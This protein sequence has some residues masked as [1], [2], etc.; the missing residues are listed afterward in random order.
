M[1]LATCQRSVS[2]TAELLFPSHPLLQ[3]TFWKEVTMLS[4][5]SWELYFSF[6]NSLLRLPTVRIHSFKIHSFVLGWPKFA[7]VFLYKLFCMTLQKNPGKILGQPNTIQW[8]QKNRVAKPSSL[9][10]SRTFHH[11]KRHYISAGITYF[12][13][14]TVPVNHESIFRLYRFALLEATLP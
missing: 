9:S 4:S 3:G 6:L 7:W 10:K 12:P 5:K 2:S 11:P 14:L 8:F 13:L 1:T